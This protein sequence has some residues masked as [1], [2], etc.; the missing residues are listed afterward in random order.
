MKS[1][2]FTGAATALI[3]PFRENSIDY[4]ALDRLLY[5]QQSAGIRALIMAGSTGEASALSSSEWEELLRFSRQHLPSSVRIIAGIG[6]NNTA[7]CGEKAARAE[8]LGCD[9]VLLTPPY[10]CKA[11]RPGILSH[12]RYVADR[13]SLPLIV[14]N[15]PSRTALPMD[16]EMYAALAEHPHICGVKEASGSVALASRTI[17]L[18]GDAFSV[19][20]GNDS[21]TLSLMA[22]GAQGV[23]SVASNLVPEKIVSLCGH[24]FAGEFHKAQ[25]VHFALE[26][27]FSALFSDVNPIPVKTALAHKGLCTGEFRLPLCPMSYKKK[28]QLLQLI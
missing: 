28:Q 20:S 14:Y 3:T 22:L 5:R 6:G 9:G 19:W 17:S 4:P 21:D 7:E 24:C 27:L 10:C 8:E 11:N 23:I 15:V 25:A 26:P 2:L 12:F 16:A 1:V 18:C 13:S